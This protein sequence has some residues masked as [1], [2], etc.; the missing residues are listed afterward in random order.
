MA[1]CGG[2][3]NGRKS[4][5]SATFCTTM[6]REERAGGGEGGKLRMAGVSI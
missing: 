5:I 2:G 1:E 4:Q 3:F 6:E